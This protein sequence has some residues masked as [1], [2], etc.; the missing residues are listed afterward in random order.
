MQTKVLAVH[1]LQKVFDLLGYPLLSLPGTS[2]TCFGL[3]PLEPFGSLPK[4]HLSEV[5]S[6]SFGN[7]DTPV[8]GSGDTTFGAFSGL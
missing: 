2:H 3:P 5:R 6:D 7:F 8:L 4:A 1:A